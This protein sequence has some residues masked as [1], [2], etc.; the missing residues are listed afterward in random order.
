L[1][2]NGY[3]LGAAAADGVSYDDSDTSGIAVA[4]AINAVSGSSGVTATVAAT[5]TNTTLV[6]S[7]P[8]SFVG[9][10]AGQVTINDVDIGVV[11][12]SASVAAQG[13]LNAA[14]INAVSDQT[15]VTAAVVSSTGVVTLTAADG[16]DIVIGGTLAAGTLTDLGVAAGSTTSAGFTGTISGFATAIADDAVRINGVNIGA[17]A[18]AD[19][20]VERGGQMA[21]AINSVTNQTGV[22]ASF[23]NSTGAVVLSAADG[24]NITTGINGATTA[25]AS[26]TTG[27]IHTIGG[28]VAGTYTETTIRS[29][30]TLSST[31]SAGIT[32]SGVDDDGLTAAGFSGGLTGATATAGAGVSSLDLTTVAGSQAA[33]T[34]LDAAIN[35]ITD[36]RASMGAY[37]NRLTAAIGNLETT[38]MNI[39]AS[40]SRIMDTDYAAETTNLA[41]AQIISQAATA[42][43]AQ[44]NQSGQSVLALLQ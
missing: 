37:Q 31:S 40:R 43:L 14:A 24:R 10:A 11:A 2:I 18:G 30:V 34:T 44:A 41:K 9:Y 21:A 8:T 23:S 27:L 1:A 39:S 26:L 22:T 33:L 12:S 15:G 20:A 4:A 36:S 13:V 25:L 6:L 42:M 35:T 17:I 16:S 38:S 32:V 29:L 7:A 5:T 3:S 19:T 28:T